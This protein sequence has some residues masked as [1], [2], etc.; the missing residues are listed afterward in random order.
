MKAP[1]AARRKLRRLIMSKMAKTELLLADPETSAYVPETRPMTAE[2]VQTMLDRYG[3]VYVKPDVGT[4][5]RGVARVDLIRDSDGNPDSYVYRHEDKEKRFADA[6]S[7]WNQL[8]Q[9]AG[10][11]KYLVQ[12]G[13]ELLRYDGRRFDIRVMMQRDVRGQWAATGM[14]ARLAHP[15]KIVTNYHSGGQPIELEP[16]LEANMSAD[17]TAEYIAGLERIG[18]LTASAFNRAYPGVNMLGLD[19]AVDSDR[20]PWIL[21]VNT[22]PDPY[23]FR[24]LKDRSVFRRVYRYALRLGRIRKRRV[25]GVRKRRIGVLRKR[26]RLGVV[27]KR[28]GRIPQRRTGDRRRAVRRSRKGRRLSQRS[29]R[30]GIGA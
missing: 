27:R 9:L 18:H 25:S 21:E 6:D 4:F 12:Q 20:R 28:P 1:A 30:K 19:I 10:G 16:L 13:I 29:R 2:H 14:I 22:N 5:G 8:L 23:I 7:L 24:E 26:R 17:Q 11:R 15:A 3:M